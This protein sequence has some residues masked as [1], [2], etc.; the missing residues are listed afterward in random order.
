MRILSVSAFFFLSVFV[1]SCHRSDRDK[2]K[3]MQS[4]SDNALAE[5][6]WND[7]FKQMDDASKAKAEIE[8][9]IAR[10]QEDVNEY[11]RR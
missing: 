3:E 2:D 1:I 8:S 6:Y 4:T 7:I 5:A 9:R 10:F 11:R